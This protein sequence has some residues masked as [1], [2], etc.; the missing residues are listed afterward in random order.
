VLVVPEK[1][2]RNNPAVRA[3]GSPAD[4]GLR[5]LEYICQRIGIGSL[6]GLEILDLGCGS[7]FADAIV[8]RNV[9][10]KS[11]VGIDVYKEM[12]DF[13][14]EHVKDPRLEFFH[15]DAYNPAYNKDGVQLSL[16]TRLPLA[17]RRFDIVCMYSVITHQL[18]EDAAVI[19][20]LLRR[21][22]RDN[23]WLFFSA[24]IEDG[25]FG[26]REQFPENPTGLS[27]YS[28]GLIAQ[29]IEAAGWQMLSFAPRVP[30]GLPNQETI[31]C[32]PT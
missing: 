2:N 18:P 22:V 24:A 9:P 19:F 11:Y 15:I 26:Y 14:A 13:L 6:A 1:F 20:T 10:L 28:I 25:D 3:M 7:R 17:G 5:L 4:T 8:N 16:D 32:A 23:G 27:V 31:L 29:L 12:I 30:A 21:H